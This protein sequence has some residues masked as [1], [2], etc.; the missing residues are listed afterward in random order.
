MMDPINSPETA[1]KAIVCINLAFLLPVLTTKIRPYSI[2]RAN[3]SRQSEVVHASSST[4]SACIRHNVSAN[5]PSLPRTTC[6]EG[7]LDLV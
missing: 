2:M 1:V 3:L 5:A 6:L 4:K 7:P